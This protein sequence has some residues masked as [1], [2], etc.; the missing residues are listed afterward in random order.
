MTLY[1]PPRVPVEEAKC[2]FCTSQDF[3]VIHEAARDFDL[4]WPDTYKVV[5]CKKCGL[6]FRTPTPTGSGMAVYYPADYNPFNPRQVEGPLAKIRQFMEFRKAKKIQRLLDKSASIFDVGCSYGGFLDQL[7]RLGYSHLYGIDTDTGSIA[8]ARE[9]LH[10]DADVASF[11]K[12]SI[13]EPYDCVIMK[14]VLDHLA[15]PV[16]AFA[17]LRQVMKVGG[18]FVL[19]LPNRDSWEARAF[20]KYW[21][22]W[23][24]PRHYVYFTEKNIRQYAERYGF[25]LV[26]VEHEATPNN[27]IW[28]LRY[29][30]LDHAPKL[31]HFFTIKNPLLVL[32]AAPL[33]FL[34][35]LFRKSGRVEYIL[36]RV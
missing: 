21:H 24:I 14:Y 22:G 10:L 27:W 12:A 8:Y 7:R 25:R 6:G 4:N 16:A 23:E 18:Y 35:A 33:G 13:Q 9:V 28:G 1:G 34:A 5:I 3:R 2:D 32:L 11:E 29:F 17:K 19:Q 30:A 20:G 26:S 31:A 36:Q 15:S